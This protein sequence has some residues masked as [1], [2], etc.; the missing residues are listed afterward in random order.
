MDTTA[1]ALFRDRSEAGRRLA[2]RVERLRREAPVVLG[3]P[4]GG[5]FVAAEVASALAA[6]LDVLVVRKLGR[7]GARLGAV[8]EGGMAIVHHERARGAG[9]G[10]QAVAALRTEAED[11]A[12][13]LA[14]HLRAGYAPYALVGRTVLLVDDGI[15]TGDSAIAAART[16]RR[17][18]AARTVLAV[19][20][21][22]A[23]ALTRLARELDEIICVD[24]AA[25][26]RWYELEEPPN[27]DEL[28][29]M[30]G[31]PRP[32][33][34]MH[35]PEGARGMIVLAGTGDVVLRRL[36]DMGFATL[37]LSARSTG[38][39][40]TAA[41]DRLAS[42]PGAER[43]AVGVLGL[44]LGAEAALVA[45]GR[46]KVRAVVAAGGRPD[47]VVPPRDTATL[48]IVGG[49]DRHVLALARSTELPLTVIP[50]AGHELAEHGALEQVAH[51]A[52]A[53]FAQHLQ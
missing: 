26:G 8:A 11:A 24:A 18:G 43:L 50:G 22:D 5:V 13:T 12:D 44:R 48:L 10:A 29:T 32:D 39:D 49:Q 14:H 37:A 42:A 46:G 23:G 19:P 3:I 17:R 52:G 45:A 31:R 27:E 30:L 47:R 35:L 53:W 7:P 41:I 34:G 20:V 15:D 38:D 16:A 1:S 40:L 28:P 9:V 6:P 4:V 36:H 2:E 51:V 25:A 33:A 21:A